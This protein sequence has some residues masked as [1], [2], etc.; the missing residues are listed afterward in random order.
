MKRYFKT[1]FVITLLILLSA[2]LTDGNSSDEDSDVMVVP[3]EM[4]IPVNQMPDGTWNVS[5]GSFIATFSPI[6]DVNIYELR[7]IREDNSKSDPVVRRSNQFMEV[8]G[9][10]FRH[11]IIAGS[12]TIYLGVSESE[13]NKAVEEFQQMLNERKHLY[14]ELEVRAL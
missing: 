14:K 1:I 11:T 4:F 3:F 5:N 9:G 6:N 2:C 12:T 13:K 7:V 10:L 8:D